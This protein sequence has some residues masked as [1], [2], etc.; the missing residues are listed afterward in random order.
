MWQWSPLVRNLINAT[1]EQSK[2][3]AAE[4][5]FE[6]LKLLEDAFVNSSKGKG[7]FGGEKLGFLDIVLGCYLGWVRAGEIFTGLKILD[8]TKTP[9]LV[10]WAERFTSNKAV[11]G[12]IPE[13][14][15]LA[16]FMKMQARAAA[17]ADA[18]S[19]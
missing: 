15:E 13:P 3:A 6:G 8:E 2:A 7:F 4:K 5:V 9:A 19:K 11:D 14:E 10:G 16:N 18:S 1:D 12:V 17:A